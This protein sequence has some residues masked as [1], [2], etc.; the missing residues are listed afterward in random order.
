MISG[1]VSFDGDPAKAR[2]ALVEALHC[3]HIVRATKSRLGLRALSKQFDLAG[4][5]VVWIT[6]NEFVHHIYIDVRDEPVRPVTTEEL[7]A[8][9]Y[10][11]NPAVLF[12][13]A[14]FPNGAKPEI[15]ATLTTPKEP[16]VAANYDDTPSGSLWKNP[17]FASGKDLKF[18]HGKFKLSD[19]ADPGNAFPGI[20]DWSDRRPREEAEHYGIVLSWWPAPYDRGVRYAIPSYYYATWEDPSPTRLQDLYYGQPFLDQ[21]GES[22]LGLIWANGVPVVQTGFLELHAA[23]LR[24]EL[25]PNGEE[26]SFLWAVQYDSVLQAFRMRKFE[27]PTT[28]RKGLPILGPEDYA[29]SKIVYVPGAPVGELPALG[30]YTSSSF[31]RGFLTANSSGSKL[32]TSLTEYYANVPY[33][34]PRSGTFAFTILKIV[35]IDIADDSVTCVKKFSDP[36]FPQTDV[37]N[38]TLTEPENIR[39]LIGQVT[40]YTNPD[41]VPEYVS[42]TPYVNVMTAP[43]ASWNFTQNINQTYEVIDTKQQLIALDYVVDTP[44]YVYSSVTTTETATFSAVYNNTS[45]ASG[46]ASGSQ[47]YVWAGSLPASYTTYNNWN[48]AGNIVSAFTS[49]VTQSGSLAKNIVVK[50]AVGGSETT[51]FDSVISEPRYYQTIGTYSYSQNYTN[52]L[53]GNGGV[54]FPPQTY[55]ASG[56][57]TVTYDE[58]TTRNYG[59]LYVDVFASTSDLRVGLATVDIYVENSRVAGNDVVDIDYTA[60]SSTN[61]TITNGVNAGTSSSSKNLTETRTYSGSTNSVLHERVSTNAALTIPQRTLQTATYDSQTNTDTWQDANVPSGNES[62]ILQPSFRYFTYNAY[63]SNYSPK[64]VTAE[65]RR[66]LIYS[67]NYVITPSFS[68]NPAV[69]ITARGVFPGSGTA[70]EFSDCFTPSGA[71]SSFDG[72]L[73][74]AW[75]ITR[76]PYDLSQDVYDLTPDNTQLVSKLFLVS[77]PSISV[78][79]TNPDFHPAG[80]TGPGLTEKLRGAVQFLLLGPIEDPGG[81]LPTKPTTLSS[82]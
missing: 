28:I 2:A 72:K 62:F 65:H 4:G 74:F 42:W 1:G 44:T 5:G 75:A 55:A 48:S 9:Y 37:G 68:V 36:L 56:G 70:Q 46:T 13:S 35:E 59:F 39:N 43:S 34:Y 80:F 31:N 58:A 18:K 52:A 24:K 12:A 82:E 76:T 64:W 11:I 51:L 38:I 33:P 7:P 63:G 67:S 10:S 19:A 66:N 57:A 17:P 45:T 8:R 27:M 29:A 20:L 50:L 61:T 15:P 81:S 47:D 49:T 41:P 79:L 21:L 60:T 26:K 22:T 23:F 25:T 73:V 78:D 54:G 69:N 77:D 40:Q 3:A 16:A 32:L 14:D 30:Q 71:T 6:D 53:N